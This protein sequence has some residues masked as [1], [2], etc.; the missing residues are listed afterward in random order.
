LTLA[1]WIRPPGPVA[2]G[3][4]IG[5][6]G[7][8]FN[9]AHSGHLYVSLTALTRLKLDYVWWLVSPGN[10]LKNGSPMSD[11]AKRFA[12]AESIARDPRLIVSD[13]ER[14]LGTR[15]TM[16]TV[17]ALQQRFPQIQFV[18]LMGSDNLENFHLWRDW[19]KLARALPLAVVQRPGSLMAAVHAAPIRQFG[20]RR[21]DGVTDLPKP[22]AI[23]ILDGAR[24][25]ESATRL[26]ALGGTC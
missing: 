1:H 2:S 22:P 10:P 8:S 17:T 24:N 6:F 3:L 12:S 19:Q 23:L 5:L 26:R 18:W 25:P 21:V 16:D 13:I 20:A 14:Q 9:P 4:K 15:Y 7:G 11:F